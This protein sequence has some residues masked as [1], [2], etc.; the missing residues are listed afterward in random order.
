MVNTIQATTKTTNPTQGYQRKLVTVRRISRKE[1]WNGAGIFN[2]LTVGD[3]VVFVYVDSFIPMNDKYKQ[4][5][6]KIKWDNELDGAK[7]FCV[8]EKALECSAMKFLEEEKATQKLL[9]SI[10]RGRSGYQKV[11]MPNLQAAPILRHRHALASHPE[12]N[13]LQHPTQSHGPPHIQPRRTGKKRTYQITEMLDGVTLIVYK[14][15][16]SSPHLQAYLPALRPHPRPGARRGD[17]DVAHSPVPPTMQAPSPTGYRFGSAAKHTSS[18]T[19]AR[20]SLWRTAKAP[21]GIL[22]KTRDIPYR[23][24]AVQ[25]ELCG[26]SFKWNRMN[27]PPGTPNEFF[28]F[29]VWDIDV[30]DYLATKSVE[31]LFRALG[32]SHVPVEGYGPVT[33]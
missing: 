22:E 23:N 19:T 33:S 9:S 5:S 20:T 4:L 12:T 21:G 11:G 24:I 13:I 10:F 17:G 7:G 15:S 28:V 6:Y 31:A 8:S 14:V 1:P 29:A 16:N 26:P 3:L 27:L 25:D 18:S 32:L 30:Q 2:I